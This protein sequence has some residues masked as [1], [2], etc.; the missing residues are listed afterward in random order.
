MNIQINGIES[1]VR[2]RA[3]HKEDQRMRQGR[4]VK[5]HKREWRIQKS[6]NVSEFC[7]F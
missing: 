5:K 4:T 3:Y 2:P 1:S 7:Y 6:E